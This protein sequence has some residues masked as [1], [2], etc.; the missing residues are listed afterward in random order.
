AVHQI[1][2]CAQHHIEL[3]YVKEMDMHQ[4]AG[5]NRV[6][7]I[8][9]DRAHRPTDLVVRLGQQ[10]QDLLLEWRLVRVLP[11]HIAQLPPIA[12]SGLVLAR[13]VDDARAH[14]SPSIIEEH[15]VRH[16]SPQV[17]VALHVPNMVPCRGDEFDVFVEEPIEDALVEENRLTHASDAVDRPLGKIHLFQCLQVHDQDASLEVL[18]R[19]EHTQLVPQ[20][21]VKP[22]ALDLLPAVRGIDIRY[23]HTRRD[24]LAVQ[25]HVM[26]LPDVVNNHDVRIEVDTAPVSRQDLGDKALVICFYGNV[27]FHVKDITGQRFVDVAHVIESDR[28]IRT[29]V[30]QRTELPIG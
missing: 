22:S 27:A 24:R 8:T 18:F 20:I 1:V 21:L 19:I 17:R 30:S 28:H 9:S 10:T 11:E 13:E 2:D 5:L 3:V 7:T 14:A 29:V 4:N 23:V 15:L 25:W 26:Q 16:R 12:S 6:P